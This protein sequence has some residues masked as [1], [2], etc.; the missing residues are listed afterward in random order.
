[1]C[2]HRDLVILVCRLS[3]R[4]AGALL[5]FGA[6]WPHARIEL[7]KHYAN[8]N[9][10]KQK[11]DKQYGKEFSG[12]GRIGLDGWGSISRRVVLP[13]TATLATP[14]WFRGIHFR[15][16]LAVGDSTLS[17]A[18]GKSFLGSKFRRVI[19]LNTTTPATPLR[20][21][22]FPAVTAGSTFWA[23]HQDLLDKS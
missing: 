11:N 12:I 20:C 7:V 18:N 5:I 9:A 21:S 1:M 22:C 16:P 2:R 10:D 17:A 23:A 3:D 14:C 19:P 4:Y 15:E 13:K 8:N 6:K